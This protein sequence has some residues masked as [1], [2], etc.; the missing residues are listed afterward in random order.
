M[1]VK[2]SIL[3]SIMLL[4]FTS[5]MAQPISEND[6]P[7]DVIVSFKYKYT[8]ATIQSWETNKGNFLAKFKIADQGGVAEFTANGK[9]IISRFA[10]VEK[11]LPSPILTY[12]K[13]NYKNREFIITVSE[14]VKE[15]TGDSYYYLQVRKSG[16]N[17]PKGS[18]LFF[19]LSGKFIKK[20]EPEENKFVQ[21][22]K[23]D[24]PPKQDT[25]AASVEFSK[26]ELP[27][28]I[29]NFIKAN[30]PDHSIKESKY[31]KD[32]EM[33]QVYYLLL[34]QQGYKDQVE[35]YFDINGELLKKID[36]REIK[37]VQTKE[38]NN[39]D[40]KETP[41][42][43]EDTKPKV[44]ELKKN[45]DGDPVA[46]AKVPAPAKTHFISKNKKATSINWFRVER[47]Y[48]VHFV[49]G[50]RKGQSIYSE[51]GNWKETRVELD[52]TSVS[53]PIMDY[54]KSNFRKL[55]ILKIENVA[56]A[57]KN[58]Y[59]EAYMVEK[60]SKVANPPVTKV[61]FDANGK[62]SSVEKPDVSDPNSMDAKTRREKQDKEFLQNV[63]ANG[64]PVIDNGTG[65]NQEINKKEL[66]TGILRYIKA[67][68]PEMIIKESRY[69]FDDDLN[70][71]IYYVT[72]KKEGDKNEI[73][74]YFN[75][76]GTLLK[77][78]DPTEQKVNGE[79]P[80]NENVEINEVV[81]GG[82]EKV[83][84]KE[85]PSGIKTYLKEKYP[86][87]KVAEAIYKT[88][89]DL[90]NVYFLVLKKQGSKAVTNLYFDLNGKL[91]RSEKDVEN[92]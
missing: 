17:Q 46:D 23:A 10:I 55:K 78:I 3:I 57:P 22:F 73:E 28:P 20:I 25:A 36:S 76:E 24:A 70:T 74:L 42:V 32:P 54:L 14:M 49:A 80:I 27:T 85:L 19:D 82:S 52:P 56:M 16:I 60:Y 77:K 89:E 44:E 39:A 38:V 91:V 18:E 35:L 31:T 69:L 64:N 83:N 30:Y 50:G 90:G 58:K 75:L 51:E 47:D 72:V 1:K 59:I 34:K 26:K 86:E 61:F 45:P 67:N 87:H 81:S 29:L 53:T 11:E 5:L 65:V 71:H 7:Q 43:K 92:E 66:P 6:V 2:I 4:G 15:A 48:V 12:Y 33:G 37:A 9:W 41:V 79:L 63:D 21:E 68:F 8:D 88:D 84:P 40:D 13:D 62:Y